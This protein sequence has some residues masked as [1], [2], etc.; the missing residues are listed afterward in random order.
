MI[1]DQDVSQ[2]WLRRGEV[3]AAITAHPG[4]LQGCDTLPLGAVRYRATA[5]PGFMAKHFPNEPTAQAL[6]AAA[7]AAIRAQAARILVG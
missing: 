2:N 4:P 7:A 6:T 1:D 5:S 3:A